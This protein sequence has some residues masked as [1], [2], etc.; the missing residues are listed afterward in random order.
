VAQELTALDPLEAHLR[1]ELGLTD[2]QSARPLLA[3]LASG[4][5]FSLAAA[6]PVAAAVL[7]PVEMILELV[8]AV[9]VAAL[10]LLGALGARAG[11]AP[12]LP[13]IMRVTGWGIAAMALTALVGSLFGVS[14]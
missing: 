3:A 6:V 10:A 14:V 5:T 9:S 7:A 12:V 2:T 11:G 4:V 1:D 8:L 13:A